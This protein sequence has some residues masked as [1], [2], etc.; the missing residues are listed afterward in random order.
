MI[1]AAAM[2]PAARALPVVCRTISGSTMA[3][4]E[5]PSAESV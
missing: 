5:F 4:M 1:V 2:V 3:A